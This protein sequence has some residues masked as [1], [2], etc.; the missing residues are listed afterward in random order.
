MS[1]VAGRFDGKTHILPVRIYYA[2]T[3]LS[4]VV[5]HANYLAYMER[6]RSEFFR[7]AGI[8]RLA[9]ME[10][11]EPTA[12]TLR[13]VE[14]EYLRPAR[15]DDLLEVHTRLTGLTGARMNAQQDVYLDGQMLTRGAIEACIITLTGK[16]RRIPQDM[17][18]K[19]APF[20]YETVT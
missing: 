13:K 4:G 7:A 16:P 14:L 9:R 19:L 15:V 6:G 11:P 5:Y 20:L 17:R 8:L 12:W 10:E 18:D 2:D 3:D 1:P